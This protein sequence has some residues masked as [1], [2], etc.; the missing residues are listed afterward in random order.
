[1]PRIVGVDIPNDKPAWISLAY[2]HG[3]GKYLARKILKEAQIDMQVRA[4]TSWSKASFVGR[5]RRISRVC[6]KSAVIAVFGI[7]AVFPFAVSR[8]RAMPVHA[9]ANVRPWPARRAL[10]KCGKKT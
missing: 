5:S 7:N 2:I 4:G 1:M 10:K 8:R 9:R 6:V 3:V